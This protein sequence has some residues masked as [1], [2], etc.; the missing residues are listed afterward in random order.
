MKV[1]LSLASRR[2][3]GEFLR[4][5]RQRHLATMRDLTSRRR[6]A[7]A[8]TALRIDYQL[9]HLEADL[10]WIDLVEAREETS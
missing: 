2:T 10:R 6:D 8:T 5:Q 3:A 9:F 1:V 7:D 4:R